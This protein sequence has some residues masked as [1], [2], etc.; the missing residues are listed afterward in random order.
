MAGVIR[1][2][3]GGIRHVIHQGRLC[4]GCSVPFCRTCILQPMR[5]G[6]F[7]LQN[8]SGRQGLRGQLH[9]DGQDVQKGARMR[10]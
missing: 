2:S 3:I 5:I 4:S 8:L 1:P 7:L 10:L 6:R 9:L